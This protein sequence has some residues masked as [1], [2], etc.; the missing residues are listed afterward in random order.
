MTMFLSQDELRELTDLKVPKAQMRWLH[1]YAYPFEV[2]A[3]GKP[4]VLREYVM[5]KLFDLYEVPIENFYN[6]PAQYLYKNIENEKFDK[7]LIDA[8]CSGEG[9]I[10]LENPKTIGF[11][12]VKKIKRLSKLQKR[13]IESAVKLLKPGGTL[14]YSTCTF[15]SEENEENINPIEIDIENKLPNENSYIK[16]I[17]NNYMEPFFVCKMTKKR[18]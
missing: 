6:Q 10:N 4:K 16:I 13:I 15:A 1:R 11:W 9:M 14:I 3:S 2:A 8:P 12:S 7:I 5:K 17:P 18:L